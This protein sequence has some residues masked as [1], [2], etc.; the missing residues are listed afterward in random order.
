MKTV[1]VHK[2]KVLFNMYLVL[3]CVHIWEDMTNYIG[4]RE[5]FIGNCG[6]Q[7]EAKNASEHADIEKMFFTQELV[8]IIVHDTN[9]GVFFFFQK[10][11]FFQ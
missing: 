7:N 4:W 2:M 6:P 10:I 1:I 5:W 3:L 9:N 8:E 11:L